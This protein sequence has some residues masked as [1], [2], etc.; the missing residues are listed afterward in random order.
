M[1]EIFIPDY[2]RYTHMNWYILNSVVLEIY[3]LLNV[4]LILDHKLQ[5]QEPVKDIIFHEIKS[6]PAVKLAY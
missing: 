2:F 3:P 4:N 1:K 6:I 5:Y